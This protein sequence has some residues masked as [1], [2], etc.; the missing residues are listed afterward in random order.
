MRKSQQQVKKMKNKFIQLLVIL[1]LFISTPVHSNIIKKINFIGLNISSENALLDTLTFKIGQEF[2]S[3]KSDQLIQELFQTGY[4]SNISISKNNDELNITVDENPYIKFFDIE[5]VQPNPWQNWISPQEQLLSDKVLSDYLKD[6]NLVAGEIYSQDKFDNFISYLENTYSSAG[7][8]NA[9]ISYETEI[10]LEN[11]IALNLIINQGKKV[12]ISSMKISGSSF[13]DENTLLDLLK[14]GGPDNLIQNVFTK[15]DEFNELKFDQG[16][17]ALNEHYI[18]SGF[19][20]FKIIDV[21]SDLSNDNNNISFEIQISEGIQFKLGDI[22]FSGEL[23]NQTTENLK[24]SISLSK[25]DVFNRQMVVDDIQK[26]IDL[27]SDQGYAFVD[28]NPLTDEFLDTINLKFNVSLNKK[29]YINRISIFGNT[30][31]QDEVIRREISISEGGLYSRSE[32]KKSILKLRRLGYF[33]NVQMDILEIENSPDKL[34][35]IFNVEETKT[36]SISSSIS[37]SNNY[38]ISIG[39]GIK[40]KNIFGTGNTL[41]ADFKFSKSYNKSSFY[42]ENP[43]LNENAHSIS[44]GAFLSELKDDDIMKDSYEI[45]SKGLTFGYGVPVTENTRVNLG[46]EF[47]QNDIKC[48]TIFATT[49][50]EST[51]C[52]VTSNDEFKASANWTQS[53]LNDYMYPTDGTSNSIR[54]EVA[55]PPGDNEYYKLNV[56]HISYKELSEN[57]TLKLNSDIGVAAGYGGKE[58]PFYRRF[59]GG[60]SGSVRGFGNKSLGPLYVNNKAKGGELSILGSA[61]LIAPANFFTDNKN[62]RVSAFIDAGNIYENTSGVKLSDIRMSTGLGFA[63][64]SPIGPIGFYW[65][66]PLMK[67]TGDII[68]NFSFTIGTGF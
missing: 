12:K 33:S 25:G 48:G 49:N 47:S 59:F 8:F 58:L 9:E 6:N 44:Y 38:G 42:F 43:Y 50:Y 46:F 64:L 2:S 17:Q 3:Y 21:L 27:Y 10:D 57:I 24:S 11:R 66:T 53:S 29:V 41:N 37:H 51:Q 30:R 13:Y 35:L 40:E 28:I 14:I 55:I 4:F 31:T 20:D 1:F 5:Q 39:A 65:S 60:G 7:F 26:I 22:S 52:A 32:L 23:G 56:N 18:N 15:K 45:S 36:G 63:Y 67:K 68:E 61:N 16:I 54:L 62:M 19:L 34:N